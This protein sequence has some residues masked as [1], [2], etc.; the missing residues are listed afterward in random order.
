MNRV[1]KNKSIINKINN[2]LSEFQE[3]EINQPVRTIS[4]KDKVKKTSG[5]VCDFVELDDSQD[6]LQSNKTTNDKIINNLKKHDKAKKN[7]L[8]DRDESL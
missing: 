4:K 5:Q 6:H 3:A 8:S 7:L 2:T 1:S